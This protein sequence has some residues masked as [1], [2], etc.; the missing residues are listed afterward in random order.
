MI[1][2]DVEATAEL[3]SAIEFRKSNAGL[4]S[5]IS[6]HLDLFSS[7]FLDQQEDQGMPQTFVDEQHRELSRS[8]Q[9]NRARLLLIDGVPAQREGTAPG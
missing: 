2:T 6:L 3:I 5:K 8:V 4:D 7:L 9:S 1:K